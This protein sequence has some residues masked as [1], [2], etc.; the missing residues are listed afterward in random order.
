MSRQSAEGAPAWRGAVVASLREA[1]WAPALV[2]VLHVVAACGFAAYALFPPL[3]IPMHLLG[4]V[5]ITFFIGHSYRV[6]EG[7]GLLGRPVRWLYFALVPALAISTTVLW[8]FAEF[9]SDRYF[10][11]HAQLGL[12]D[13]LSDMV[14]GCLGSVVFLVMSAVRMPSAAAKHGD[15]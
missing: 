1:G 13:T 14:L 5:A 6:A 7:S 2:F 12:E 9:L 8:E 11:T 15:V 4:G 3:D 10:G